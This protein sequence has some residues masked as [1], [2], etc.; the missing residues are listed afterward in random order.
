MDTPSIYQ[1]T[2][3]FA[4][5]GSEPLSTR[6]GSVRYNGGFLWFEDILFARKNQLGDIEYLDISRFRLN[7]SPTL[8][9]LS[10]FLKNKYGG[11]GVTPI[12]DKMTQKPRFASAGEKVTIPDEQRIVLRV[13]EKT[14]TVWVL[15]PD[16][17]EVSDTDPTWMPGF[18]FVSLHSYKKRGFDYHDVIDVSE[19]VA[20]GEIK[21]YENFVKI[22]A[23]DMGVLR[24]RVVQRVR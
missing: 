9:K 15:F 1:V 20:A 6:G 10:D 22:A 12:I 16:H 7:F 4:V 21:L 11:I 5:G 17:P 18:E 14:L 8:Y 2:E 23:H 13:N 3:A 24:Y 19:P